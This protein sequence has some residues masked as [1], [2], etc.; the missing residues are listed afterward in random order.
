M[1]II[2]SGPPVAQDAFHLP[3]PTEACPRSL[4][5][6]V[7]AQIER[8]IAFLDCIDIDSDREEDGA[9]PS[10]HAI[11]H[12]ATGG[13][14]QGE[15]NEPSIGWAEA[16]SL[17]GAESHVGGFGYVDGE[18]DRCDDENGHD[19]EMIEGRP[20]MTGACGRVVRI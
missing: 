6:A 10:D 13:W 7:E 20:V 8:L 12:Y 19:A 5:K 4:R 15:D 16:E 17:N 9:D 1:N 14:T 3:Q 2:H 18:L 11:R